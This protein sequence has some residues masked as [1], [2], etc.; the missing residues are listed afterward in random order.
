[1]NS[2]F[3]A[4]VGDAAGATLEFYND[5]ITEEIALNAMKMPGGGNHRVGRGQITDDGELTLTLWQ[6]IKNSNPTDGLP[7]RNLI[8]AYGNWEQS[9]PFDIGQTSSLA[10][11]IASEYTDNISENDIFIIKK[12][13]YSL[14]KHSEANGALMR[15]S[16]IATWVAQ[17]TDIPAEVGADFAIEDA[18]LSH[19]SLACKEANAIYVYTIINLLRGVSVTK[20]LEYTDDFIKMNN[21][22]D[23]VKQWYYTESV[24]ITAHDMKKQ[25]GWV[26][27]GFVLAFYFLRHPDISYEQAIKI[28]L[29]KGG[30][31][32]TNS[33]IVGGM[34]GAYHIIP[35]YM[36]S[37]VLEFDCT[38]DGITRPS[39]YSVRHVLVD[40]L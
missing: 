28:T 3:G 8:K 34:V 19:P 4:L 6:A 39:E 30:D 25:C 2:I 20:V 7:E 12:R 10:F 14:N 33:A 29:M 36:L 22:S 13:V 18:S 37:P 9:Y 31:T 35:N 32:D 23:K 24:D 17:H 15:A 1:M 21:F 38:K 27:W 26:R 5:D 11:G 40:S 16:A